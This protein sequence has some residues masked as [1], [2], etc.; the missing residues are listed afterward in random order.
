MKA[1]PDP[2]L[3]FLD[4]SL[5]CDGSFAN[6]FRDD[7]VWL[8]KHST[9]VVEMGSPPSALHQWLYF[10]SAASWWSNL[11]NVY[12]NDDRLHLDIIPHTCV[13]HDIRKLHAKAG[14]ALPDISVPPARS[15]DQTS[16]ASSTVSSLSQQPDERVTS[17]PRWECGNTVGTT[18]AW[19]NH[20]KCEHGVYPS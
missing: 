15:G 1:A 5:Q 8:G 18:K 13:L 19:H 9:K 6:T 4:A 14:P 2:L 12:D 17:Y 20:R 11:R 7:L 10:C 16:Q 3:R